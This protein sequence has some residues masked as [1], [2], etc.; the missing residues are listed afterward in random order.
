VNWGR[1]DTVR[2]NR[3]SL[4]AMMWCDV[5]NPGAHKHMEDIVREFQREAARTALLR[6]KNVI[7]DDTNCIAQ[8]RQKWNELAQLTRVRFRIVTMT[9]DIKTCIERDS[10][11]EGREKVGEGV[12]RRQHGDLNHLSRKDRKEPK[13]QKLTRPYFERQ[14]LARGEWQVRL[15]N[16]QWV[17]VDVDG[18]QADHRGVR[19]KHDE[20]RVLEDNPK[21]TI[22][23][24]VRVLYPHYNILDMSGRHDSCGDDTCDWLDMHG[25]PFD[26]ILMRHTGDNRSDVIAKQEMLDEFVAVFG[27]E[28]IFMVLDDR[29]RVVEMWRS[30]GVKVIPVRGTWDHSESCTFDKTRK[31]YDE[32]P[33][34]G[35]IE[36]Y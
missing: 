7:I 31:G 15:P 14:A 28:S 34:C 18:T 36:Y 19:H 6:G 17:I 22:I 8:T 35:A 4:R 5:P 26:H 9:T 13:E 30:N 1:G 10:K 27:K 16:A 12:I 2:L 3:D 11:R 29:P 32:C 24:W 33:E 23:E 25:A 20:S 21:D